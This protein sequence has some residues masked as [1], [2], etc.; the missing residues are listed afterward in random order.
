MRTV[1]PSPESAE[2][3]AAP[4]EE[5]LTATF[6][7]ARYLV[8]FACRMLVLF[9]LYVLSIG[10]MYWSW[11]SGKYANG[12]VYLAAFYEP[13]WIL[14]VRYPWLGDW[15]DGYVWLWTTWGQ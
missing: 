1:T 11:Y 9:G 8:G 3:A 14:C 13:L 7:V 4:V 15:V 6:V 10:P 5:Q 12:S 2:S